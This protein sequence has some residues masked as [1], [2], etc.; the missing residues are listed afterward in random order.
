M[1]RNVSED[2]KRAVF[3]QNTSEVFIFLARISNAAMG[4]D[5]LIASDPYEVLP[6]AG[7]RGVVHGGEEYIYLPFDFTF[8]AEDDTGFSNAKIVMDNVGREYIAQLRL[9]RGRIEIDIK[10]VLSSDV[11]VVETTLPTYT[12]RDVSY[13]SLTIEATVTKEFFELEPFPARRFTPSAFPGMF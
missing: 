9:A 3:A 6:T 2:F 4:E 10:L 11:N 13:N 1:S 8:P 12:L 7:V 5:I